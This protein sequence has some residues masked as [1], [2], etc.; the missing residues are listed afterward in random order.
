MSRVLYQGDNLQWLRQLDV[1]SID[2]CY[3]DPPFNSDRNHEGKRSSGFSDVWRWNTAAEANLSELVQNL[4]GR[5]GAQ[6]VTLIKGLCESIGKGSI[7]AYLVAL[8]LRI[9]EIHRVLKPTGS[10]YLHCDPTSS[11][12]LKVMV[13]SIFAPSG[14]VFQNEVVWHYETGGASKRRFARKHDV[15]LF[16]TKTARYTFNSGGGAGTQNRRVLEACPE[17]ERRP[18]HCN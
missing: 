9:V 13:D 16:Y 11:H 3:I 8:V 1:A 7:L 15:L 17:S 6:T 2:L 12:Y 14:G 5:H 10:F 18:H 4:Q